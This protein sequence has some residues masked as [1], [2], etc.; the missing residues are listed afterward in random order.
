MSGTYKPARVCQPTFVPTQTVPWRLLSNKADG[1]EERS[2]PIE[3]REESP[4]LT[5][6]VEKAPSREAAKNSLTQTEIY[7][8]LLL[9]SQFRFR[10]TYIAAALGHAPLRVLVRKTL[11]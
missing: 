11:P 10:T 3:A 9:A 4:L 6:F 1:A 5:D 2:N 7:N 8:R